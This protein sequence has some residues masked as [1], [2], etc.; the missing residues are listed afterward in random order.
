MELPNDMKNFR[1][2]RA[3]WPWI[4]ATAALLAYVLVVSPM[5]YADQL[6]IEAEVK[7]LR[8]EV[9]ALRPAAPRARPNPFGKNCSPRQY[10]ADQSD[11]GAWLLRCID[12]DL[13]KKNGV[14]S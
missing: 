11:G 6:A 13:S 1:A 5:D 3:P 4:I 7:V 2:R 14:R 12:L 9:A 10:Y 8:A